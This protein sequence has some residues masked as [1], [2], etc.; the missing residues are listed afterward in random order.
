[1]C[2]C[3]FVLF[4]KPKLI[5]NSKFNHLKLIIKHLTIIITP[6]HMCTRS[7]NQGLAHRI[8][9]LVISSYKKRNKDPSKKNGS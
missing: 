7:P 3:M 9:A 4:Q 5:E 6:V 2:A 8:S 1:M